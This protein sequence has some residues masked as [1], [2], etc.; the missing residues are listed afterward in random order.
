MR[1][2]RSDDEKARGICACSAGCLCSEEEG[3]IGLHKFSK[4]FIGFIGFYRGLS[5]FIGFY[6]VFES[7]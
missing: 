2:L 4:G 3:F 7:V 5:G 6:R 1:C